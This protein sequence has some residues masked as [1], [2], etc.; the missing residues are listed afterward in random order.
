[1]TINQLL[2]RY[3]AWVASH[4]KRQTLRIYR[5]ALKPFAEAFGDHELDGL[6]A[7]DVENL[8]ASMG[9]GKAANTQRSQIVAW[10]TLQ[11]WAIKYKHLAERITPPIEKPR[12]KRRE[13]Y[14][15][16]EEIAQILEHSP[17]DFA[18]AYR[19]LV[20]CGARPDEISRA[21]VGNYDTTT[22]EITLA[23][24]KT[25]RTG[26]PRVIVVGKR[27]A[28]LIKESLH[29]LARDHKQPKPSTPIFAR[30]DGRPWTPS[31]L[32]R[33][34]RAARKAAKLPDEIKLYGTRHFFI[35]EI[36]K[37]HSITTAAA[38]AGHS[39]TKTTEVYTHTDRQ[40]LRD[41]QDDIGVDV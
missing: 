5:G 34:F 14:P 16:A 40:H 10:E 12:G 23:T 29:R 37:H 20:Q 27:L 33:H 9:S 8:L 35:S 15:S 21:T 28:E 26:K 6:A 2:D 7:D 3:F 30:E 24:H 22:G 41:V 38:L 19:A 18:L 11:S 39:S 17:P 1:M 36:C 4:R 32:G 31:A 25:E 13:R